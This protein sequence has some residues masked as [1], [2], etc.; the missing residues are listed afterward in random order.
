VNSE[1]MF[2]SVYVEY[3]PVLRVL[4]VRY[5]LPYEEVED[6]IQETFLS[7][8][9]HYPVDW[10]SGKMKGML[11]RI[12]KNKCIDFSRKKQPEVVPLDTGE[13]SPEYK[14]MNLL[15]SKDSLS[16]ILEQEEHR[17]VW[18]AMRKMRADWL[19]VF[20][21]YK[22]QGRPIKEVSDILGISVAACRTRISRGRKFLD[23]EL[24]EDIT[25]SDSHKIQ[26][27]R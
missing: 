4:A 23:E 14:Y 19:E 25:D 22:I 1:A 20:V 8:F 3:G 17:K 5:G 11:V 15:I 9:T 16:I 18:K 2:D 12:L 27:V 6:M 21:L 24:T 7:Y 13:Y 26:L 10:D